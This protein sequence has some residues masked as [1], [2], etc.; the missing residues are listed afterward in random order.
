ME[1]FVVLRHSVSTLVTDFTNPNNL[2]KDH[3]KGLRA[4]TLVELTRENPVPDPLAVQHLNNRLCMARVEIESLAP[5]AYVLLLD[6]HITI[7]NSCAINNLF[8]CLSCIKN[9]DSI[10]KVPSMVLKDDKPN[11]TTI[12]HWLARKN[13]FPTR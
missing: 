10:L 13:L 6:Y 12:L 5:Q 8:G 1:T 4:S 3:R 9:K 7:F 2:T 11:S